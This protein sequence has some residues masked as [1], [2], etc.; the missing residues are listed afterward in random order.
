MRVL[1]TGLAVAALA[2]INV[3]AP[4]AI[5]AP[6]KSCVFTISMTSGSEVNNLDFTVNYTAVGGDV[7][8]TQTNPVCARALPG[9]AFAVFHDDDAG[10]LKVALIRLT[11]FSAPVPLA[12]CQILYDTTKP[13]PSDFFVTVTNAGR[14]GDD[15]QIAPLPVVAVTNVECPGELPTI[16][17]TTTLP[18]TTTT[19]LILGGDRCGFP[20]TDGEVP[21]ASDAL[22]ALKAGVGLLQCDDCVCDINASG[23]VGASDALGILRAAVGIETPLDCPAC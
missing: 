11:H 14:D 10:H 9:Q 20:I 18:D 6:D 22:A 17:T 2:T 13:E 8:G 5:A 19:T 15:T 23:S 1:L 21:A 4:D 12:G 7:S 3:G 16:T